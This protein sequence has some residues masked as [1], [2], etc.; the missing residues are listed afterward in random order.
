MLDKIE[1]LEEGLI[2]LEAVLDTEG[3]NEDDWLRHLKTVVRGKPAEIL[4][5]LHLPPDMPYGETKDEPFHKCGIT[6][7]S[8]GEKQFKPDNEARCNSNSQR[9]LPMAQQ[10]LWVRDH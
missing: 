4:Q 6:A 2:D 3:A 8:A 5:S 10:N 7:K 9:C 1:T